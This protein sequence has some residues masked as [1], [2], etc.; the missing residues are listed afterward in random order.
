MF[1]FM[2][3]GYKNFRV[4]TLKFSLADV[5]DLH[6]LHGT[7]S[8]PEDSDLEVQDEDVTVTEA[9]PQTLW[10][11]EWGGQSLRLQFFADYFVSKLEQ[12]PLQSLR[13]R[14]FATKCDGATLGFPK[15]A[16]ACQNFWKG[17]DVSHVDTCHT[18]VELC[19]KFRG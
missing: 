12:D 5:P 18:V 17:R 10:L 16:S 6:D 19:E 2:S 8:E 11:E 4:K 13:L 14:R 9:V 15:T 7:D 3:A 1:G